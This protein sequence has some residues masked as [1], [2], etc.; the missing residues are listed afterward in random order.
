MVL[1]STSEQ[2]KPG[3]A[4]H[5]QVQT[6]VYEQALYELGNGPVAC[7]TCRLNLTMSQSPGLRWQGKYW[8][9]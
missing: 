7:G 2:P 9:E 4:G 3:E 6:D 1:P 8:E 5:G